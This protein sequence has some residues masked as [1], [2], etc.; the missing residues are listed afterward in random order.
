MPK[1][2]KNPEEEQV[3]PSEK[4][5]DE[6]LTLEQLQGKKPEEILELYNNSRE[7]IKAAT[8]RNMETAEEK[9]RIKEEREYRSN[10]RQRQDAE[11][12]RLNDQISQYTQLMQQAGQQKQPS[13][14]NYDELTPE[15]QWIQMQ[16]DQ[17]KTQEELAEIKKQR[18]EDMQKLSGEIQKTQS[19]IKYREF[20]KEEIFPKYE[21]VTEQSLD[22]W[23]TRHPTTD[24]NPKTVHTAATEIQKQQD[25]VIESRVQARLKAKAEK[26]KE[27]EIPATGAPLAAL[28]GDKKFID[29][30]PAEQQ[31]QIEQDV[32]K[33]QNQ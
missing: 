29:M 11:I 23:F 20:L 5:T 6:A 17:R 21:F 14:P 15:Q 12:Q 33:L 26:A 4:A 13:S 16:A 10:E 32:K 27:A 1:E 7:A 8:Q 22:D 25:D 9:Q 31:A 24:P 2:N 30:T 3:Q 28:P 19:S 18:Q